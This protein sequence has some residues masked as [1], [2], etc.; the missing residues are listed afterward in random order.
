MRLVLTWGPSPSDLDSE[1]KFFDIDGNLIC[2]TYYGSPSSCVQ[3]GTN[4][5]YMHL[6]VDETNVSINFFFK[7]F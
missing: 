6:D 4:V 7:Y 1:V 5:T 3:P 2:R